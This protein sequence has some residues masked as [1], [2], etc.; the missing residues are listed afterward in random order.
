MEALNFS[1]FCVSLTFG[2]KKEKQ[3]TDS[4][5]AEKC[6]SVRKL[7]SKRNWNLNFSSFYYACGFI[8]CSLSYTINQEVSP[9][10]TF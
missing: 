1:L 10:F 9:F 2:I 6:A 8:N 5:C 3:L 7:V 4:K